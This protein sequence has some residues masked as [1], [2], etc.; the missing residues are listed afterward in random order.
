MALEKVKSEKKESGKIN[1][2][3]ENKYNKWIQNAKHD[4]EWFDE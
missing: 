1:E 2:Y 4:L 3:V